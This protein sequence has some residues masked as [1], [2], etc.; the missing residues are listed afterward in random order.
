MK[1]N[2]EDIEAQ[3]SVARERLK[4]AIRKLP[5]SATGVKMLAPNCGTVSF[6]EIAKHGFNLSPHYYLSRE[7]K[8]VLL[9]LIDSNRTITS[10]VKAVEAVLS[11]GKL[12]CAGYTEIIAPNVLEALKEAWNGKGNEGLNK[13]SGG[14]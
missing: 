11:T 3:T 5:D 10:L 2:F 13:E 8:K 9:N 7:T 12:K 14:A 1:K 4:D 6:S